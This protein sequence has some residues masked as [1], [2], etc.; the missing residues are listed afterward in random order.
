MPGGSCCANAYLNTPS[1]PPSTWQEHWNPT[2]CADNQSSWPGSCFG[3]HVKHTAPYCAQTQGAVLPLLLWLGLCACQ[4]WSN[5][6][7]ASLLQGQL[8]SRVEAELDLA[9]NEAEEH[10]LG[11][12]MLVRGPLGLQKEGGGGSKSQG[13]GAGRGASGRGAC[14]G[15]RDVGEE[16]PGVLKQGPRRAWGGGVGGRMTMQLGSKAGA[17][18]SG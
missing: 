3:C 2:P 14:P 1:P 4:V 13:K 6:V 15:V 10:A 12:A 18:L 16:N 7:Q 5:A 9:T 11:Y 17:Q 8:Q